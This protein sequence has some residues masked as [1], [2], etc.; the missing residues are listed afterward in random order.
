MANDCI[1]TDKEMHPNFSPSYLQVS[2]AFL[3]WLC[4]RYVAMKYMRCIDPPQNGWRR[5]KKYVGYFSGRTCMSSLPKKYCALVIELF[6]PINI[7]WAIQY[8]YEFINI[9]V[10]KRAAVKSPPMGHISFFLESMPLPQPQNPIQ[11]PLS[12]T[13]QTLFWWWWKWRS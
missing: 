6:D 7:N 11:T 3:C 5:K 9:K 2:S 8:F 4:R 1:N 13:P 10:K 12:W